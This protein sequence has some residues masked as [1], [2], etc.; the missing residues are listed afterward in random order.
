MRQDYAREMVLNGN[1][2][3]RNATRLCFE[4]GK[5]A[6]CLLAPLC[7][8]NITSTLKME[9]VCPSETSVNIVLFIYS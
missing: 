3:R 2:S 1:I 5:P 9:A 8:F 4:V 6:Y 7:L